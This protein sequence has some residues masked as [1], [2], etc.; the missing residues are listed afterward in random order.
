MFC[1]IHDMDTYLKHKK[2]EN[3]EKFQEYKREV[4]NQLGKNIKILT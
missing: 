3:F 1:Y 4:K 2:Y